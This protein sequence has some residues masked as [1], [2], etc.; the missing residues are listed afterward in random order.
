MSHEIREGLTWLWRHPLIRALALM[1]T[2]WNLV[3]TAQMAVFV[4][5]ALHTL[6]LS[7]FEY[8]LLLTAAALGGLLGS[9]VATRVIG[10]LGPG[11]TLH[12]IVASAAVAYLGIALVPQP[13]VVGALFAVEGAVGIIWNVTTVSARQTIIPAQLFGRVNSVYRF[14]SWGSIPFGALLGGALATV[15]GLRAPFLL[16]AVALVVMLVVGGRA[17]G[18]RAFD[19]AYAAVGDEP[20]EP[21]PVSP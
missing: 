21:V 10:R 15:F 6:K 2:A 9:L 20:G 18:Q 12:V 7:K 3:N 19:A 8:S 1:L 16:S 4:L 11:R 14:L 17:V 5:F 13:V